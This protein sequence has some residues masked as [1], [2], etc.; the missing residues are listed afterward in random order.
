M[1]DL[2]NKHP[3]HRKLAR[4]LKKITRNYICCYWNFVL[5][6][7]FFSLVKSECLDPF[8]TVSQGWQNYT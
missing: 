2:C 4:T 6:C 5:F 3:F 7:L 8:L 1:G